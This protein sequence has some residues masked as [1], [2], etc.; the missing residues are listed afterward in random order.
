MGPYVLD[1]V[2]LEQK[3]VIEVD[4]GQHAKDV[5]SD[6]QR[7]FWLNKNGFKVLRFW[8]HEVLQ[9]L[10]AVISVIRSSLIDTDASP[11]LSPPPQGGR[12]EA[13]L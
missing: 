11:H 1:F 2:C 9:N 5:R 8:N 10:E 4:G 7:T 12:T 13:S 6:A 3:L